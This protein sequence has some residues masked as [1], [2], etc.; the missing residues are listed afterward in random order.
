[1]LRYGDGT[2]VLGYVQVVHSWLLFSRLRWIRSSGNPTIE[3]AFVEPSPAGA[4]RAGSIYSL[5][6]RLTAQTRMNAN[7]AI[8]K[9]FEE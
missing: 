8:S 7:A 5:R 6:F 4:N 9:L 1:M 2:L 3:P